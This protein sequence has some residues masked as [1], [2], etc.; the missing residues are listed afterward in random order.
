VLRR[1]CAASIRWPELYVAVNLSAEQFR[2]NGFPRRV[3]EIVQ[4]CGAD[5]SRIELEITETVLLGEQSTREGLQALKRAGFKIALDDFGTGHSSLGYLR[6]FQVDKIKIDQSFVRP[7]SDARNDGAA[8][9]IQ[10]IVTL[11][12]T[13]GL[14]V[15]AEGVE[16]EEQR[17]LLSLKGCSELQGFLFSEAVPESQLE[18]LLANNRQRWVG[19][20]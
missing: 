3:S 1:A 6:Q 12:H 18:Q 2:S 19:S 5:P 7:L 16:T 8:P 9:I 4:E 13:M 14:M 20:R 15:S 17:R 10:A 11:G